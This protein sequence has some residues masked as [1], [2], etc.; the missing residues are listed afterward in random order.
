MIKFERSLRMYFVFTYR[1][2]SAKVYKLLLK[3]TLRSYEFITDIQNVV[4][5]GMFETRMV[6]FRFSIFLS[7]SL[8]LSKPRLNENKNRKHLTKRRAILL[9]Q[10]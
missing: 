2:S 1:R 8:I 3:T 10:V 4:F 9:G 7:L 5:S 6:A